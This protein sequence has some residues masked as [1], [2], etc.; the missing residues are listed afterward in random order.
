MAAT[1]T[2]ETRKSADFAKGGKTKMFGAQA[3]EKQTSGQTADSTAN[4]SAPGAKF[5]N[6][7]SAKM[8]GYCGVETAKPGITSAR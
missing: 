7:G 5:A 8:F 4:D 1:F 2:K 3:A 6:G